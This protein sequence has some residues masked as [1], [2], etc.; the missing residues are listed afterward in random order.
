[1]QRINI[2]YGEEY[3]D[4]DIIL[5]PNIVAENLEKVGQEF[6]DWSGQEGSD[7]WKMIDG[8]KI[9]CV[10]TEDFMRW[11]DKKYFIREHCKTSIVKQHTTLDT[12]LPR[13][14]F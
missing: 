6:L 5:V 10:D 13:V 11:I 1:M 4:V 9:C 3:S 14:E 2:V 7:C 12:T 8:R